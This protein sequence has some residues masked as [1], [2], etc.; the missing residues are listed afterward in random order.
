MFRSW[1]R[2][3]LMLAAGA[4]AVG[5][6]VVQPHTMSTA[7]AASTLVEGNVV[8]WGSVTNTVL[9]RNYCV[10][11]SCSGFERFGL[12]R[13]QQGSPVRA[14]AVAAAEDH[15][16]AVRKDGTVM[17]W[18]SNGYGQLGDGT[19]VDRPQAVPVSGLGGVVAVAT[20]GRTSYALRADGTVMGWGYNSNGEV[21]DGTGGQK[22]QVRPLPVPVVGLANVVAIAAG[23]NHGLALKG[24][25]TVWAWGYNAYGQLGVGTA[26]GLWP[27]PTQV[28]ALTNVVAIAAGSYYSLALTS[29]G[30]VW[31]WGID[32]SGQ[33]G[34]GTVDLHVIQPHPTPAQV[35]GLTGVVAIAGSFDHSV[36]VRS[37]GTVWGWGGDGAGQLGNGVQVTYSPTPVLAGNLPDPWDPAPNAAAV[38][39]GDGFTIALRS[40]RTL[41]GFGECHLK[42]S[43]GWSN[44]LL[45][46]CSLPSFDPSVPSVQPSPA[47]LAVPGLEDPGDSSFVEVGARGATLGRIVAISAGMDDMVAIQADA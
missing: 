11:F 5:A 10:N 44:T 7:S 9:G 23:S 16:L 33:L 41:F 1:A 37:D 26:N 31:A 12:V 13:D 39:A 30:T 24:D 35:G 2:L 32:D 4:L 46:P 28:M 6:A 40:D 45:Y 20:S 3:A 36:A 18:G 47:P 14:V 15:S 38:T 8:T 27:R 21:G 29:D 22:N 34:N 17:A 19:T 25:G 42:L 43:P